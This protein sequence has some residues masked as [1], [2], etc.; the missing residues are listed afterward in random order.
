MQSQLSEDGDR[1]YTELGPVFLRIPTWICG[2][3]WELEEQPRPALLGGGRS[4]EQPR[5]E[6]ASL[7]NGGLRETWSF[8]ASMPRSPL[9]QCLGSPCLRGLILPP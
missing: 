3:E 4:G 8:T 9:L 5:M 2:A 7:Q 1:Y 6:V